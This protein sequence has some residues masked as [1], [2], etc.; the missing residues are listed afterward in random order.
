MSAGLDNQVREQAGKRRQRHASPGKVKQ[1]NIF[2]K[3]NDLWEVCYQD[4]MVQ[5]AEVKG[6]HDLVRLMAAPG[7]EVHCTEIMGVVDTLGREEAS[8]DKKALQSYEAR[9]RELREEI[10]EADEMNDPVRREKCSLELEQLTDH[11]AKAMGLGGRNRQLKAPAERARSAVTWR[12]RSAIKKIES[13]HPALG[14]HLANAIRTGT[15]CCYEPEKALEWH[16]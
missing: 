1:P 2:R 14:R 6:F 5:L 7:S 4:K 12:I 10:E 13:A 3:K 8:I 9:I 15:F 16:L 11:I